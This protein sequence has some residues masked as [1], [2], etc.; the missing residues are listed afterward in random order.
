M[1]GQ[2]SAIGSLSETLSFDHGSTPSETGMAP[3]LCWSTARN[4]VRNRISEY[5]S[6]NNTGSMYHNASSSAVPNQIRHNEQKEEHSRESTTRGCPVG[7]NIENQQH[8][9]GS[10][11]P[12]NNVTLDSNQIANGPLFMQSSSSMSQALNINAESDEQGDDCQIV[13]RPLVFRSGSENTFPNRRSSSSPYD[14]Q[15]GQYVEGSGSRSSTLLEDHVSR[16]RKAPEENVG[17]SSGSGSSN[18]F[19]HAESSA[20]RAIPAPR[21]TGNSVNLSAPLETFTGVQ[22]PEQV[23]PGLAFGVGDVFSESSAGL[24]ALESTEPSF[25]NLR[26]RI[27]STQ[28]QDSLSS[29]VFTV[30]TAAGSSS[31]SAPHQASRLLS[32]NNPLSPAVTDANPEVQYPV[33]DVSAMRRSLHSSR[34]TRSSSSRAGNRSSSVI[35][36]DAAPAGDSRSRVM[37]RSRPEHPIF[38]SPSGGRDLT[39]SRIDLNSTAGNVSVAENA[40]VASSSRGGT[41]DGGLQGSGLS[42]FSDRNSPQYTRRLSEL[43]RRT[44][45]SA[46][47]PESEVQNTNISSSR[48]S[49]SNTDQGMALPSEGQG[50]PR[51]RSAMLLER[52][53]EGASRISHSLRTLAAAT[54]GRSRLVSEIRD[55]LDLMRRGEGLR[56]EDVMILDQSFFGLGDLHD[57]HRDMRLDVDNMSY[58]ELL[59]LE[60]RIGDVNTGVSEEVISSHLKQSK[61]GVSAISDLQEPE[62]CCIC[63]DEYNNGDDLGELD[64]GHS[65]HV[66]CIKEWL[67]RK[68]LCPICKT[69]AMGE[70]EKA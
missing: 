27:N 28:Q 33:A 1:Q 58:E 12:S 60:E 59:A 51:S 55:V 45:S 61:Y 36:G 64:C 50:R 18:H 19:Q 57:R 66:A 39:P 40:N 44:L 31:L 34:W 26:L 38:R 32:H 11:L 16:K 14:L 68:N 5:V 65:F 48:S 30:G 24:S 54:E 23:N 43:V 10:G 35:E 4:I 25:R 3:P 49:I 21:N 6:T 42:W 2:S 62:P 20:W 13:E 67:T 41:A 9:S 52:H 63:Q 17:Q 47:G 46:S 8:E 53:L 15:S 56:L 29:N 37:S 22:R 7:Q 70:K 69:T